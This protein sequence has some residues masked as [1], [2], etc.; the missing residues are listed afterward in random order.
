[1]YKQDIVGGQNKHTPT[2]ENQSCFCQLALSVFT[3]E[4]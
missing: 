4:S 3:T 1:M 2:S